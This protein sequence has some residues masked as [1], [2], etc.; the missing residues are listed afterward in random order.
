MW[1]LLG[2]WNYVT[3]CWASS[4]NISVNCTMRLSYISLS[5]PIAHSHNALNQIGIQLP[6]SLCISIYLSIYLSIW[7]YFSFSFLHHV[8]YLI[9]SV[10]LSKSPFSFTQNLYLFFYLSVSLPT[11][12]SFF[13]CLSLFPSSVSVSLCLCLSLSLSLSLFLPETQ[14][15]ETIKV[16]VSVNDYSFK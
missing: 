8:I 11:Y 10:Y 5:R 14:R 1:P 4:A 7:L 6:L 2:K 13:N 9:S 3:I 15:T 16:W 12:L